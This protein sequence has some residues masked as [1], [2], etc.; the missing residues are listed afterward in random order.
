MPTFQ[1]TAFNGEGKKVNGKVDAR[2]ENH[3]FQE[4]KLKGLQVIHLSHYKES[5]LHK[6]IE[7]L[8]P[9]VKTEHFVVFCRQFATLIKAGIGAAESVQIL[10][11]QTESKVLKKALEQ[12]HSEL[13]TGTHLSISFQ[14][15]PKIFPAIFV[16]MVRAGEV[17][18]N[19]DDVLEKLANFFEKENYT[20][21][22]IKSAM[23]YPITVTIL[24]F[25]VTFF[26]MWKVVP[27][28]VSTFS[29]MGIELPLITRIVM[30]ISEVVTRHW[31]FVLLLPLVTYFLIRMWVQTPRGRYMIDLIK[32]RMP[33][34]GKLNQKAAMARFCRTFSS[35]FTAAV[36]IFQII[37]IVSQVVGNEVISRTLNDAKVNLRKGQSLATPLKSNWVFPPMVVH[38]VTVGEKTG[39][40][41]SVL[42]KVADFYESDVEQMAERL[43]SLLEPL[44][45]MFVAGVVGLIVLAILLPTFTLY[46]N[47]K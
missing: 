8:T 3:A 14:D 15:H 9:K 13:R 10:S 44:M 20:R 36:P 27:Q 39:S 34:F 5:I 26:L 33:I 29:K 23:T 22:K 43:K 42:D 37:D 11:Q 40:L 7:F 17:S 12:V 47:L 32:L 30:E 25:F 4:L 31:Y 19:L 45:I 38:M 41:D 24:A 35:L 21:Q 28:F 46:G 1:Y 18:G 6:D 2:D 16:S